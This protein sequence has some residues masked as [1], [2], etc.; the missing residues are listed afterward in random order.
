MSIRVDTQV[1]GIQDVVLPIRTPF[2][3]SNMK[4]DCRPSFTP[5]VKFL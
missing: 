1:G 4:S 2:T 3:F 5:E